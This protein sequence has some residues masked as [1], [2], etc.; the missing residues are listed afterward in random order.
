MKTKRKV[1][2]EPTELLKL[3]LGCGKNPKEGF[4][5]VDALDFGQ[6]IITDLRKPW[7]WSDNSVEE[8]NCSHFVEH[9]NASDRIHFV[10]ELYRVLIPDGKAFVAVPHW[11]S[12]RAYG[13]LTHQWPPISEWW[14]LYLNKEWRDSQA[15]HSAYD[16]KVNFEITYGYSLRSD[17]AA[18]R[19]EGFQQYAMANYKDAIQDILSTWI[20]K[21]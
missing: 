8:V 21:K 11:N 19:N 3:D 7:P 2:Q 5:G 17:I 20:A 14:F 12:P 9:L 6:K 16:P 18:N 4:V 1:K 13:D 15:P 10:N